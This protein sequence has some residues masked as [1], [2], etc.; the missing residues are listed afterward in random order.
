MKRLIAP[1]HVARSWAVL[2]ACVALFT[3]P[4]SSAA[5]QD[6]NA[7][8]AKDSKAPAVKPHR[9]AARA[10][11]VVGIDPVTGQVA[12]PTPN[13]MAKLAAAKAA[14]GRAAQRPAPVFHSNGSVSLDVRSWMREH[15]V[16]R[17][18]PGGRVAT[19]C[20]DNRAPAGAAAQSAPPTSPA[21]EER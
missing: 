8:A 21:L 6:S 16:V 4:H 11:I 9:T 5:T 14:P 20:F 17:R 15:V 19:N 3:A 10:G 13:Q 18:G 1:V 2:L 7:T 12:A